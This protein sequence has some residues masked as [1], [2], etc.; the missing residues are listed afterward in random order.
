MLSGQAPFISPLQSAAP[1]LLADPA[2]VLYVQF[3]QTGCGRQQ[4]DM[5]AGQDHPVTLAQQQQQQGTGSRRHSSSSNEVSAQQLSNNPESSS[6][7]SCVTQ[8]LQLRPCSI[9][10]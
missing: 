3:L 2:D 9:P 8:T 6:K 5:L 4:P 10:P 1:S 7:L